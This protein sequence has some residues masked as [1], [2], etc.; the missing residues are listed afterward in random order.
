MGIGDEVFKVVQEL[1]TSY[2]GSF[3]KYLPTLVKGFLIILIGYFIAKLVG[4]VVRKGL[5]QLNLDKKLRK[6]DLDD[7]FGK[8]SIAKLFGTLAKWFV[9]FVFFAEG[10]SY[11]EVGFI[12]IL[13]QQ[14]AKWTFIITVNIILLVLGFLFIDFVLY[15]IWEIRTKYDAAI[16][17]SARL[18]V[19]FIIIFTTLDQQGINL[20]FV[21]N[22]FLLLFSALLL[23]ASLAVGIGLGVGLSRNIDGALKRFKRKKR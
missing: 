8:V 17:L 2:S 21:K 6:A 10:I 20:S 1:F 4:F 19:A 9:F 5:Y 14:L 7:S 11:L 12:K 22:I 18:F 13:S 16:Q 15:K 23:S 3:L